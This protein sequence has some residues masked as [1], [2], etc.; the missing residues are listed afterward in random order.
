MSS[1]GRR[2]LLRYLSVGVAGTAIAS[3]FRT[4]ASAGPSSVFAEKYLE[5]AQVLD[6]PPG[7][8]DPSRK[9][10]IEEGTGNPYFLQRAGLTLTMSSSYYNTCAAYN[11]QMQ[12]I[13]W[14]SDRQS[15]L[16]FNES[17][18]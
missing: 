5:G 17:D 11:A 13:R 8:Y 9:M 3:L 12:C 14:N 6:I 10:F 15:S 16:D 4:R 7:K 1:I 2:I 18:L